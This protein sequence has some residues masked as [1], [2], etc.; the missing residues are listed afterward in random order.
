MQ[1]YKPTSAR[2]ILNGMTSAEIAALEREFIRAG[3]WEEDTRV[4]GTRASM[5]GTFEK[6]II[7]ADNN[8]VSW[9]MQIEG[10]TN[11]FEAWKEENPEPGKAPYP[12]F[13]APTFLKP[14][15]ATLA[16]RTKLQLRN[17]LGRDPTSS[18]MTLLTQYLGTAKKDEWQ[19][20]TYDTAYADWQTR[21]RAYETETNQMSAPTVQGVDAE[22]RFSEMFES[23]YENELDHRERVDRSQRK[24]ANLFNSIDTISRMTS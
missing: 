23:R 22:A 18:E 9:E 20:N 6:I 1:R 19:A 10:D 13:A 21:A 16:Q 3:Y 8:R 24:S 5:I 7:A 14:D 15:Y 4:T 2:H 11:S 12:S 17:N